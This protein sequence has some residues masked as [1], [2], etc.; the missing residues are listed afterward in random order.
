MLQN[1]KIVEE[2]IEDIIDYLENKLPEKDRARLEDKIKESACFRKQVEDIAFVWR[3]SKELKMQTKIDASHNWQELSSKIKREKLKINFLKIIR[4][5]AAVLLL[6]VL[7]FAAILN[8][9][10]EYLNNQQIAQLEITSAYGTVSRTILPDSSKVWLNSGTKLSYPQ[11]FAGNRRLVHLSGEAYFKVSSN[12]LNRFDVV[13]D[14]LFVSAYGTEFNV[15]S[16]KEDDKVDVTLVNGNIDVTDMKTDAVFKILPEQSLT[17]N[18]M[19]NQ[20]SIAQSNVVVKTGWKDGKIVFRRATM[21]EITKRLSRHFNVDIHLEGKELYNY[22][23][24][25]TFT[26]ETLHEVLQLLTKTAPIRYVITDPQQSADYS[27]SKKKVTIST[28]K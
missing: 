11:Q 10:L 7:L 16:Y 22:E 6:P 18:R 21:E 28:R 27:F 1:E 17:Y 24:S 19:D 2:R 3:I 25:A 13:A 8:N 9:R 14:G 12:K 26:T 20:M 5:S 4:S 23:Y 15:S